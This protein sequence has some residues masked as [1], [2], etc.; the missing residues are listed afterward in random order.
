MKLHLFCLILQESRHKTYQPKSMRPKVSIILPVK[1]REK[2]LPRCLG[3]IYGQTYR[4]LEVIIVDNG[5]TDGTLAEAQNWAKL[6]T[7][8]SFE[9]KVATE[10]KPG[11]CAARNR[12][13]SDASGEFTLF[14]DSDDTMR[15]RLTELAM[16]EFIDSPDTDIVCWRAE[17]HQL[18]GT[19][20]R[21]SFN[22]GRPLEDH[23]VNALLRTQGYMARTADFK[24]AGGWDESLPGWNDW[25]LGVR[26]LLRKPKVRALADCLVDIY[27]QEDSITGKSFSSKAG[28]WE[29]SLEAVRRDIEKSDHPDKGRLLHIVTYRE[30]ILAAHYAKEG[31]PQLANKLKGKALN[32][33]SLSLTDKILLETAYHY[34]RHGGR[35]AWHLLRHFL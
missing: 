18:D 22:P 5:S 20:R 27:A 6:H 28:R 34:T 12:G 32:D 33:A 30:T 26:L 19:T 3:S 8:A 14:F 35:G 15:P 7:E 23:L 9:V 10:R 13:L 17:I 24:A 31:S 25:E 16:G 2:L 4:P 1:D 11:A 21:P 29:K